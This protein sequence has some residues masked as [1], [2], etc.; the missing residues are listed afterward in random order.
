MCLEDHEILLR[1]GLGFRVWRL[2]VHADFFLIRGETVV[3]RNLGTQF[4]ELVVSV[5][6]FICIYRVN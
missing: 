5:F 4:S 1:V 2:E 6:S 3:E